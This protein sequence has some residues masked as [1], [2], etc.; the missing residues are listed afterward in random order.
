[1]NMLLRKLLG[2]TLREEADEANAGGGGAA[3]GADDTDIDAGRPD[4][5][6]A[7]EWAQLSPAEREAIAAGDGDDADPDALAAIAAAGDDPEAAA[8][9]TAAAATAAAQAA[10]DEAAAAAADGNP[11]PFVPVFK[12]NLPADFETQV[13]ALKTQRVELRTQF[14]SGDLELDDYEAQREAIDEKLA[15]L[16]RLKIKA[17]IAADNEKQ[18]GEQRWTWECDTFY[19]DEA[20]AIYKD[21]ILA[22]AHNAAVIDLAS[23]ESLKAHPERARWTGTRFLR[24]ADGTW[25]RK[26]KL[27]YGIAGDAAGIEVLDHLKGW[28]GVRPVRIGNEAAGVLVR[29]IAY[30]ARHLTDG[31]IHA[32]SS[33]R[34][35]ANAAHPTLHTRHGSRPR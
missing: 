28:R 16:D 8:A 11:A 15:E 26:L 7:D 31:A 2:Y 9:A 23:E 30:C 12:A 27:M 17:E 6:S 19:A 24:E 22:A 32:R 20:N 25:G 34:S 35:P 13:E 21:R 3:A 33:K 5:I 1:M 10:E 14:K 18:T 4:D 29:A